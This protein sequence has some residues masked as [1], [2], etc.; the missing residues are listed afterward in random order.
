MYSFCGAPR[1]V[2]NGNIIVHYLLVNNSRVSGYMFS[3]CFC[4]FTGKPS[5]ARIITSGVQEGNFS[6]SDEKDESVK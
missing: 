1:V 5:I 3:F 4:C 6:R 2:C